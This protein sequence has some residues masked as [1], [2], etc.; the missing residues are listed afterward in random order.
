MISN[1]DGWFIQLF[2]LSACLTGTERDQYRLLNFI[3][4]SVT[5]NRVL[6]FRKLH[7]IAPRKVTIR[8]L[9][10]CLQIPLCCGSRPTTSE[11]EQ[12]SSNTEVQVHRDHPLLTSNHQSHSVQGGHAILHQH[13]YHG[14]AP[15]GASDAYDCNV[16][17]LFVLSAMPT[18]QLRRS[19]HGGVNTTNRRPTLVQPHWHL[20]SSCRSGECGGSM[21]GPVLLAKLHSTRNNLV[22]SV[23]PNSYVPVCG[24]SPGTFRRYRTPLSS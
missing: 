17:H 9:I 24:R 7:H 22:S 20:A 19:Y 18:T 11:T 12:V 3:H 10:L 5:S 1:A 6:R 21:L 4:G 14:S 13:L 2:V 8:L 15:T 23:L 16:K